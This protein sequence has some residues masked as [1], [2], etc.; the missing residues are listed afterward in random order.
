MRGFFR[1]FFK[2]VWFSILV[3]WG[4]A[5]VVFILFRLLPDPAQLTMGQRSDL[6]SQE[7]VKKELGLNKPPISQYFSFLNDLSVLSFYYDDSSDLAPQIAY[8]GQIWGITLA[9]KSPYLNRS[10]QTRRPVS[11]MLAEVLPGTI[12]LSSVSLF[13]AISIGL[14]LGMIAAIYHQSNA[15]SF[16]ISISNLGVSMPSFFSAIIVAWL[17]GYVLHDWTGLNM[18]GTLINYDIN[19]GQYFN[20][21]NLILPSIALGVRPL[22]IIT[23]LTRSNMIDALNS[24][25]IT[26]AKAKG[27]N[28]M[29]IVAIHALPNALN[30]V[31]TA[32]TGW[33]AS[34]LA[35]AFFVEYIFGWKGIGRLTVD[36]LE[37]ADYPVVSG[38]VLLIGCIFIALNLITDLAYKLLDPRVR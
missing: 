29:Q 4:L 10:F 21:S 14:I 13:I 19:Q 22:A 9:I 28:R 11:E 17:F 32:I 12:W 35:G 1:Y 26:T 23:Q 18:S 31:I 33:F 8:K 6:I 34:L 5:T 37:K 24:D 25:F 20:W 38:A 15:D 27:L 2:K 30:P 3:I 36:A 16:I 7:A